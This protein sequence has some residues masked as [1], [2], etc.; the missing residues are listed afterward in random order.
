MLNSAAHCR[1]LVE[2]VDD[3]EASQLRSGGNL[4]MRRTHATASLLV[5][6]VSVIALA[7]PAIVAAQGGG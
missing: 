5:V 2:A 6:I 1:A 4:D 7:L 3:V